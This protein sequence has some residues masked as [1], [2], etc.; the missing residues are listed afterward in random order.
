MSSFGGSLLALEDKEHVKKKVKGKAGGG[1]G[2]M[3]K[4]RQ[5]PQ[6]G[7]LA[8]ALPAVMVHGVAN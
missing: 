3:G 1:V 4:G 6:N 5:K 2:E 8:Q 7:W